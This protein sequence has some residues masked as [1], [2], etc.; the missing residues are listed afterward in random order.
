MS[1]VVSESFYTSVGVTLEQLGFGRMDGG[2]P[3]S[4][5]NHLSSGGSKAISTAGLPKPLSANPCGSFHT[6]PVAGVL[7]TQDSQNYVYE[8]ITFSSAL[9][10]LIYYFYR[11]R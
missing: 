3:I 6:F 7:V 9:L 8:F 1:Q 11:F 10:D 4:I 5:V 2:S